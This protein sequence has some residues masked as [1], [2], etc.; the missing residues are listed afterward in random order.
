MRA[1]AVG[2]AIDLSSMSDADDVHDEHVVVDLIHDAVVADAHP[3]DGVLPSQGNTVGR[4]RVVGEKIQGCSNSLLLS[5]LEGFQRTSRAPRK[6]DLVGHARP[7][8]ALTCS[9]GM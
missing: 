9:H 8:S 2:L 6:P 4:P 7:R 5:P 1:V 3:V